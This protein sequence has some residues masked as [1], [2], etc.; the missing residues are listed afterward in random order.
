[1][2]PEFCDRT[3]IGITLQAYLR[4]SYQ[5]LKDLI[6]WAKQRG[7]PISVRLIKGAYWDSETII[8]RQNHWPTPVYNHKSSTDA[9]FERM[10]QLLLENHEYLYAAIG[11]HNVR[12]QAHAIAIAKELN[13]PPRRLEFQVLYGMADNLA[14]A[15]AQ[16]GYRVRVY[17]PYGD[18]IPGMSYLIRRLLENT[19]NSSFLKQSVSDQPLEGLLDAPVWGEGDEDG[20]QVQLTPIALPTAT[21]TRI[22]PAPDTDYAIE[23]LRSTAN[24]ALESVRKQ[25]GQTYQPLI[26]GERVQTDKTIASVNPS[27][28]AE[29]VG[30]IGQIDIP[31]A[32]LA[33]PPPKSPS[34]PGK[35]PPPKNAPPSSAERQTYSKHVAT[36]SMP[37]WYLR[38]VNPCLKRM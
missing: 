10:T 7:K 6:L 17:C 3:D 14:T 33:S 27:N 16:Q 24:T 37:G 4:D 15:I 22:D 36:N 19:A 2:E 35:R 29:I 8:A 13:I 9:N 21:V 23:Q 11:S 5:D 18:L 12:S 20:S 1:M 25:L 30:S 26:N 32:D 38:L 28:P 34:K 31:Q